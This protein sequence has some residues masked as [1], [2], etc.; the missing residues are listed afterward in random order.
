MSTTWMRHEQEAGDLIRAGVEWQHVQPLSRRLRGADLPDGAVLFKTVGHAAWD[1]AA[2]RV[3][4]ARS[5][6]VANNASR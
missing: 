5:G 3:A 4:V 1:L 2:A 6:G